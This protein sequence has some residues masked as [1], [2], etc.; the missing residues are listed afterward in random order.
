MKIQ[1]LKINEKAVV[2][3]GAGATRGS[4]F[5]DGNF[6]GVPLPPLDRDFFEQIQM[7]SNHNIRQAKSSLIK[8]CRDEFGSA[9]PSMELFFTYIEFMNILETKL[10][11]T[12]GRWPK[13]YRT[14]IADF[15]K[16]LQELFIL[17]TTD[18][19]CAYHEN[20][21]KSLRNGDCIM[22]FN[23]DC[24]IDSSLRDFGGGRWDPSKGYGVD[25]SV[26]HEDWTPS[27]VRRGRPNKGSITL[28]K[29]HGSLN[30][31]WDQD[32][33]D[34]DGG[35]LS[36]LPWPPKSR[37]QPPNFTIVPPAWNKSVEDHALLR[38]IWI[39]ARRALSAAKTL[40]VIGYSAPM[41]DQLS[42]ALL[43]ACSKKTVDFKNVIIV[44]R[45]SEASD[46]LIGLLTSSIK[47][48]TNVYRFRTFAEFQ[49]C[50][51]L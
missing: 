31:K 1:R 42:Q 11:A 45:N 51:A 2:I 16:V 49:N 47:D 39:A 20:L 33:K 7:I 10:R 5:A 43:R 22:S 3:L 15:N 48:S 13:K 12:R 21:V 25:V 28:L 40:V 26:G 50:L 14:A 27:A 24:I 36:L 34:K 37:N 6:S 46:R 41:N 35:E 38:S 30:W 18:K 32:E 8:F 19:S 44:N 29:M 17:S 9:F 23:Y 4:S